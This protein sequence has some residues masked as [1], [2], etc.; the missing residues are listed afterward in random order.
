MLKVGS[1]SLAEI[2]IVTEAFSTILPLIAFNQTTYTSAGKLTL[3]LESVKGL[4]NGILSPPAKS[5]N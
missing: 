3:F 4:D 2:V 1:P 5:H